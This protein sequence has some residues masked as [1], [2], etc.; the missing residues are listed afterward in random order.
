[1]E[2]EFKDGSMWEGGGF[3]IE[4]DY[5]CSKNG[6]GEMCKHC[7]SEKITEHKTA[8][9]GTTY[10]KKLWICPRVVIAENEGGCNS[11]GVC[12]DCIIEAAATITC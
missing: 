10:F 6:G 11:T 12:L 3:S 7:H 8:Y 2:Y 1:M 5:E 9:D 4:T